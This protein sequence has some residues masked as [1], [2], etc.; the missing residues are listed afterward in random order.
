MGRWNWLRYIAGFAI[1]CFL[2]PELV[3]AGQSGQKKA[4]ELGEIVV[5]A[6]RTEIEASNAPASVT[7]ITRKDMERKN[8]PTIDEALKNEAGI[9]VHRRKGIMD[10]VASVALR[11]LPNQSRTLVL[12]DGIPLN[13]GY[14]GSI[15]WGDLSVEEVKRIEAIRGPASALWGGNAMGG[16]VNIITRTPDRLTFSATGG[17]GDEDTRRGRLSLGDRIGRF[18]FLMGYEEDRTDG[19]PAVPV[20]RSPK[21]GQG[22]LTGGYPTTD[23]TGQRLRWV[24]GD[25]GDNQGERWNYHFKGA[26]DIRERGR[27][28]L[29][30]QGGTLRYSYGPPNTYLR[31][32]AGNPAFSGD[33]ALPGN[34]K[35]SV[36][37]YDFISYAGVANYDTDI[38]SLNY[39]DRLWKADTDFTF[40]FFR[41]DGYWTK[42]NRDG[43][44]YSASGERNDTTSESYY[45]DLKGSFPLMASHLV[46]TGLTF[47]KD[48]A[49]VGN[50]RLGFYQD[51]DTKMGKTY[52]AR[53][54]AENLGVFAQDEISLLKSLDLYLGLRYD[55]W[56]THDGKAGKI[57]GVKAYKARDDGAFSPKAALVFRPDEATTLRASIGRAFRPPSLYEL[58]RT[59][60][61]YSITYQSNPNLSPETIWTTEFG[62]EKS[63]FGNRLKV[64]LTYYHS[65]L[66][67]LIYSKTLD[68][69]RLKVNAGSAAIDG[70]E[71]GLELRPISWLTTK[72]N[73]TRNDSKITDN[74]AAPASEGKRMIDSP[75]WMWNFA[76]SAEPPLLSHLPKVRAAFF[77]HYVG[78]V[79]RRDDNS[80]KA[81]GVYQTSE[82]HFVADL[83][84][85][86]T[87]IRWADLSLSVNNIFD[88]DYY[89]YYKAPGRTFLVELSLKY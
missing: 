81:E 86:I 76:L 79:F 14:S 26:I 63:L 23:P 19:Y 78:K 29:G 58:Y 35:V 22:T 83:K 85:S 3:Q 50:Y 8:L 84:L 87:P 9:Y 64:S 62:G 13:D 4:V 5:T 44:Y 77:G 67:D 60:Q 66:D 68:K 89:D 70:L 45:L 7:V 10:A 88:D 59:W 17:L 37:P 82:E 49:E 75:P 31:D 28:S 39:K 42:P 46:T 73:Y 48:W 40:G 52:M 54:Q 36:R 33:V 6:T 69:E 30:Y 18:S 1:L 51:E 61:W 53:G 71:A 24:V 57:G 32:V 12:L 2:G 27:L 38:L 41:R 55:H 56:W 74:P 15:Q 20:L 72:V 11:G 43:D 34:Q 21:S 25:K 16:V 65:W 47:R 80:D